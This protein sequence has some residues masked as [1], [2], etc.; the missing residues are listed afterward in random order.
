MAPAVRD[1][2]TAAKA[3]SDER[4]A[5]KISADAECDGYFCTRRER[6]GYLERTL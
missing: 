2:P 1:R 5:I 6:H 3:T 4:W